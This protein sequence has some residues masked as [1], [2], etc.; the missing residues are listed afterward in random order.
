[1]RSGRLFALCLGLLA[2]NAG[3]QSTTAGAQSTTA[4]TNRVI[5]M[6]CQSTCTGY[7]PGGLVGYNTSSTVQASYF[8]GSI[9]LVYL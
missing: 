6:G 1:M 7:S 4:F 9:T 5:G 3:A 8:A 2:A